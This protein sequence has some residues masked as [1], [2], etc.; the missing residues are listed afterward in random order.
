MQT[1]C[2]SCGGTESWGWG[3]RRR[4]LVGTE[5][6][7]TLWLRR[8]RCRR[9]RRVWTER[10]PGMIPRRRYSAEVIR[11]VVALRGR[12]RSWESCAERCVRWGEG[13]DP[14]TLR[15]WAAAGLLALQPR[16]PSIRRRPPVYL[17]S[18]RSILPG[19]D[20]A[21]RFRGP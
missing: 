11:L 12:G 8:R 17:P 14:R 5:G 21:A 1:R 15:R 4:T 7:Q 3:S 10:P 20:R 6:R 2:P 19:Q 9:C 16:L 13:P 18:C